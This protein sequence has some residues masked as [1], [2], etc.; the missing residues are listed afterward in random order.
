VEW[1]GC[2]MAPDMAKLGMYS[3]EPAMV[4]GRA[5]DAG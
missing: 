4:A 1:G 3:A 2:V 5:L